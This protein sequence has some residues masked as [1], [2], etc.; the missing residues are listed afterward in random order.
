MKKR[1]PMTIASC[2]IFAVIAYGTPCI[3]NAF[4]ADW[5]DPNCLSEGYHQ[6]EKHR[7]ANIT[8]LNAPNNSGT[9]PY[10]W[11]YATGYG[12]YN[13]ISGPGG[14]CLPCYALFYTPVQS[15]RYYMQ[16]IHNLD[17]SVPAPPSTLMTCND[18]GFVRPYHPPYPPTCACTPTT[19]PL[20]CGGGTY[21]S[22][23]E[24]GCYWIPCSAS[25]II[26][27]LDNDGYKLTSAANGVIFDL[28]ALGFPRRWSWTAA[29]SDEAFLV[30]DRN[31]NGR[32][33]NGKE[34]F[35]NVTDQPSIPEQ[36][37]F[38]ALKPFDLNNDKWIDSDD[39]IY[40]RLRLWID[41]NHNGISE[42]NEFRAL[43][44]EDVEG[45]SLNYQISRATDQYGNRFRFR[46]PVRGRGIGR[47]AWD[48]FFVQGN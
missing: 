26:V 11:N 27:D 47:I 34:L 8:W 25:P 20:P 3:P 12:A 36:N 19:A 10:F 13:K 42:W 31:N 41:R 23:N 14:A 2:L 21:Q 48:V 29:D 33:D 18:T 43:N 35:G 16:E 1:F 37:G 7:S 24:V 5:S 38:N 39:P 9:N 4:I 30:L 6:I 22:W 17:V 40:N 45:I 28:E 15:D 32:I 44:Q 46:A